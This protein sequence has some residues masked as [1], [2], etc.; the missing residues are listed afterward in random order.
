MCVKC[1]CLVKN[2][3]TSNIKIRAVVVI[4][5]KVQV[6]DGLKCLT[7]NMGHLLNP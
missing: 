1:G 5:I 2:T 6:P 3:G 4:K 7:P